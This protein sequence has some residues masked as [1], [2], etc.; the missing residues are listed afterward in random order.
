MSRQ[1]DFNK[2]DEWTDEDKEY[3]SQRLDTVPVHLRDRLVVD[4][5]PVL[6][7]EAESSEV[8]RLREF[9]NENYPD[10]LQSGDSP[11]GVAIRLLSDSDEEADDETAADD[12]DTLSATEIKA[13]VEKR[14]DAGRTIEPASNRKADYIAALRADDATD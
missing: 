14:R 1:I 2:P 10:E 7:T 4:T 11:V 5:P 12:Y 9:L 6:A 8:A 13:E 3:L